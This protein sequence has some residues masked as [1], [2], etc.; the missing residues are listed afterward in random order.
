MFSIEAYD[1]MHPPVN[2]YASNGGGR[3]L[4]DGSTIDA[5]VSLG[6]TLNFINSW[7]QSFKKHIFSKQQCT[8]RKIMSF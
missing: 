2:E 4:T 1:I 3:P 6:I 7:L 8:V 5:L